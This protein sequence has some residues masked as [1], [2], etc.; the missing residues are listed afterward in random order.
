MQAELLTPLLPNKSCTKRVVAECVINMPRSHTLGLCMQ[1]LSTGVRSN[2]MLNRERGIAGVCPAAVPLP[3]SR[4]AAVAGAAAA[5]A[6][7]A[8]VAGLHHA[9]V[10]SPALTGTLVPAPADAPQGLPPPASRVVI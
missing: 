9:L 3:A 10:H 8:P 6:R 4:A 5:D 1:F 7:R 2:E